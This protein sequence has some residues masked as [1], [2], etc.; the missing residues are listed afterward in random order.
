GSGLHSFC[1]LELSF[2]GRHILDVATFS[3][4]ALSLH[5]GLPLRRRNHLLPT[6]SRTRPGVRHAP[7]LRFYSSSGGSTTDTRISKPVSLLIDARKCWERVY[8]TIPL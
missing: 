1:S 6:T 8:G 5:P 3:R 7:G 2:L 4:E